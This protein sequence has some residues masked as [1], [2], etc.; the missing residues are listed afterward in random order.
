MRGHGKR[1]GGRGEDPPRLVGGDAEDAPLDLKGRRGGR[2]K[3]TAAGF[4][5][6]Q[7]ERQVLPAFFP[8]TRSNSK[9]FTKVEQTSKDVALFNHIS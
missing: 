6:L 1:W 3:P 8:K 9:K 7:I 5:G 2:G 4:G